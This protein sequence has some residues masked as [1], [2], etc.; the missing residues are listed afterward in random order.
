MNWLA[1]EHLTDLSTLL[2]APQ[3]VSG[4]YINLRQGGRKLYSVFGVFFLVT[5]NVFSWVHGT[6]TQGSKRHG[7]SRT[8]RKF[9]PF[10]ASEESPQSIL[11]AISGLDSA[12][13]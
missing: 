11:Q 13:Q 3:R 9:G 4:A 7:L 10:M 6:Q 2:R 12:V 5:G 8:R 1:T